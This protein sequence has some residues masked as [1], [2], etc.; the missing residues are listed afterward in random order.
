MKSFTY[1]KYSKKLELYIY[2]HKNIYKNPLQFDL[3][4]E[5]LCMAKG[6]IILALGIFFMTNAL[7]PT[8]MKNI[9]NSLGYLT[10]SNV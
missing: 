6:E 4:H 7:R 10:L 3:S 1:E 5:I 2:G 9:P 8:V